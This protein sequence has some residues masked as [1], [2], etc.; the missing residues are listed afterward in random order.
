MFGKQ[1]SVSTIMRDQFPQLVI[2]KCSC[3]SIH[4]VGCY[5]V[6][7]FPEDLEIT[8]RSIFAH[9]SRSSAR[10]REFAEFQAFAGL[11]PHKLLRPGQTRWLSLHAT[12]GRTLEQLA[13]LR[14]YFTAE[15]AED[16]SK[17]SEQ[18][19]TTLNHP[20][21]E[22]FLIFLEYA[23]GCLTDFNTVFQGEAPLLHELE[24]RVNKLIKDFA[25]NFMHLTYVRSTEAAKIDPWKSNEYQP[26]EHIYL[27]ISYSIFK[28]LD[29][30]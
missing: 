24:P 9:F 18:I 10:Q 19:L 2:V 22:P 6:Q 17:A 26:A 21:T 13:A 28:T 20:L 27:G 7:A 1:H 23:L 14:L 4:L 30:S 29:S 3:H 12:V 5:A 25:S 15:V 11:E 16:K 8:L